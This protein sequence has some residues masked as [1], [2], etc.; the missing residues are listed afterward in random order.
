MDIIGLSEEIRMYVV[1]SPLTLACAKNLLNKAENNADDEVDVTCMVMATIVMSLNAIDTFLTD[2]AYH[3]K[4]EVYSNKFVNNNIPNKF[5]RLF[6]KELKDVFPEVEKLRK[7]R[8]S[9]VHIKPHIEET[10]QLGEVTTIDVARWAIK[11]SE[12]FMATL[13]SCPKAKLTHK[14]TFKNY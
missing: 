4:P 14:F 13:L 2:Y 7:N 1:M 5:N 3:F 9:I 12:N 10:R 6:D 8:V 11:T